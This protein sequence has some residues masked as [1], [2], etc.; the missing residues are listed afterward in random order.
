MLEN[1]V[2][3]CS[4]CNS[5]VDPT[6]LNNGS[7]FI[8][9]PIAPQ[10]QYILQ[11]PELQSEL[12]Y[13]VDRPSKAEHMISDMYDG[14][15]YKAL[16]APGDMLSDP[17]NL[18]YTFNSD[19]A[20]LHKSS[21][22][23]IW[24]IHLHLNELPPNTRFKHVMLAGL[25]FGPTEP[26]M[27]VF[28]K[29]FVDQAKV[30]ATKGVSWRKDGNV[31]ISKSVD[32]KARPTMQNSTQFNGYFGCGFCLYPGT[33]VNRQVTYPDRDAES[34]LN[35]MEEALILQKNVRGIKG[36]SPLINMPCFD[37]VW[38]FVPDYMHAVLLGVARQHAALLLESAD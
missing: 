38:G 12:S 17:N 4:G 11:N 14:D 1:S 13:R 27:H 35:D 19:G 30:L 6:T 23:S 22:C 9:I 26:R 34:M 16:S 3:Q 10:I 37:I 36:P 29:P 32:S 7:F 31:F 5:P 33:L 8:S 20:P 25:W 28:L 18:S 24:P 2:T 15:L 21:T